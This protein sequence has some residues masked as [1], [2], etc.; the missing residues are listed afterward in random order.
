[1][2]VAIVHD[3]LTTY[4]GAEKTLGQMLAVFPSATLYSLLDFMPPD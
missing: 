4:A 1:M 2:R 3:W